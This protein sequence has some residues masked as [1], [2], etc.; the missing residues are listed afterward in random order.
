M[1]FKVRKQRQ[2]TISGYLRDESDAPV[3]V[4]GGCVGSNSFEVWNSTHYLF[5]NWF[6][7]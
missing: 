6:V 1:G 4:T 5:M 2:K 3:T 7:Y